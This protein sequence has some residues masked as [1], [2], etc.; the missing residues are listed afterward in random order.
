MVVVPKTFG[1]AGVFDVLHSLRAQL[2]F[3][4]VNVKGRRTEQLPAGAGRIR[5]VLFQVLKYD[6]FCDGAVGV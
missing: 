4:S 2:V 6:V 1:D 3:E 5:D